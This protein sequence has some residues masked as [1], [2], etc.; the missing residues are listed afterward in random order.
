LQDSDCATVNAGTDVATKRQDSLHVRSAVGGVVAAV[1]WWYIRQQQPFNNWLQQC[2]L[3]VAANLQHR[4]YWS[5]PESWF[6]TGN[7]VRSKVFAVH[8]A[9]DGHA[10]EAIYVL[11]QVRAVNCDGYWF[12]IRAVAC[13]GG[14]CN[15]QFTTAAAAAVLAMSL[16]SHP[17]ICM[18]LTSGTL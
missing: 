9:G 6:N 10:R 18:R 14:K 12:P 15:T 1:A 13:Q 2:D 7:S 11:L 4:M 5:F 3:V 16:Q 17:A 8:I